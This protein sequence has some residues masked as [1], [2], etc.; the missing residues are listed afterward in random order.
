MHNQVSVLENETHKLFLDFE[1]QTAHLI[2]V[3]QPEL[4]IVDKKKKTRC[5]EDFAVP[6]DREKNLDLARGLKKYGTG[7]WRWDPL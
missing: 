6:A 2:S 4:L 5:L 1:I 7:K 3:R